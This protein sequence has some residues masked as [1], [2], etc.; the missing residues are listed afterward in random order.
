M[1]T[2]EVAERAGVNAQ[3]L[4]YYERR[5]IL[6]DPP[7]S[8]AGYR[9]YPASAVRVLRFVKRAQ[10]LGFTLAEV[11]ELLGLA[12]GGPKSCNVARA[13]AEAHIAEL[14]RKIADLQRMRASLAGLVATCER[15]P[16]DRSCPLLAA[17]DSEVPLMEVSS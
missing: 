15:P 8:A 3:T 2:R 13:L 1:R 14:E 17:I 7:R 10:E 6:P 16:A 12:E 5:G 4:R 9:D 11:E